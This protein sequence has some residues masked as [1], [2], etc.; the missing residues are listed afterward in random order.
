MQE[1]KRFKRALWFISTL[2]LVVV[3]GRVNSN[4][5]GLVDGCVGPRIIDTS[6]ID[7]CPPTSKIEGFN[8]ISTS[9][10]HHIHTLAQ[11]ACH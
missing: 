3:W 4:V 7:Q 9:S 6:T 8:M 1:E 10:K 11:S 2:I 5:Y